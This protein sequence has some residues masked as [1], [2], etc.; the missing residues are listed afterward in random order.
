VTVRTAARRR[1]R[2]GAWLLPWLV[3]LV[4]VALVFAA[5]VALGQALEDQPEPAQP[6]TSFA[7][8]QP[9]TQTETAVET[10]TVTVPAP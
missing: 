3:R 2:R 1:R 5:G 9:W 8:I 7:T 6:V 10:R 4:V